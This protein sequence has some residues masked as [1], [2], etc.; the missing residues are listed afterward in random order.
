MKRIDTDGYIIISMTIDEA[1]T[2]A[3]I[4]EKHDILPSLAELL[5]NTKDKEKK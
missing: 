3:D 5:T 2:L 1:E 4:L